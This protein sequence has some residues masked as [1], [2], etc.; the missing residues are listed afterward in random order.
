MD[1]WFAAANE[2]LIY[3]AIV[4][5]MVGAVEIGAAL[6]RRRTGSAGDAER[7]ISTLATPS[8][9]LLA[10]MIAF[11]FSMA[12][13]RFDAR[14]SAVLEEANA[15]GTAA[16][17]GQMLPEPY[18]SS[19]APL[20]KEYAQLR[21]VGRRFRPDSA[22]G[23]KAIHRSAELHRKLWN[24]AEAA[25][26]SDPHVVPTGLFVQALNK[27]ID[28]HEVRLTAGRN[29]VPSLVFFML[30]GI[31]VVALGF[32]GYG[33]VQAL[34]YHRLAML[35]LAIL[36]GSVV[37]LVADLDRPRSGVITVSQQPLLDLVQGMR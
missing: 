13:T 4:L 8:M 37:T 34:R 24:E 12:L 33:A 6:G 2:W 5:P 21:M 25:A 9:G 23:I 31:A 26:K 14:K 35:F 10:L 22:Q 36:I 15:I 30:E 11:T 28:M 17:R 3:G 19:V 1:S 27:M 20:F 32:S 7:V 29:S 18:R 16:L